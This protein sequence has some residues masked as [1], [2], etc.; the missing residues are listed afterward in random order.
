M[1][2][3]VGGTAAAALL[4]LSWGQSAGWLPP[5]GA[6]PE[7]WSIS[8][9]SIAAWGAVFLAGWTLMTG[10]MMLP[11][12]LPFLDA[13]QR[14]GGRT[15]GAVAGM[16]YTAVW[17]AVGAL[18]WIALWLAGDVLADLGPGDA[19]RIA[20]AS[21]I[22]AAIFHSTPLARECQR[23][24]AQPFAILALHWGRTSRRLHDAARA[25]LHYGAN[26]VGCCVPM[27]AIMF[28]VGVHDV[29]WLLL[30]ALA[31]LVMKHAVWGRRIALPMVAVLIVAG[32]AI[33]SGWW[34]VPLHGLRA[35]CR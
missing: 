28:V 17:V 31:M 34:S 12:S 15:A 29:A 19:E 27:V 6:R 26:C 24:C 9:W 22:A 20:G 21:L 10:A 11:S 4:L 30:M 13:V 5:H 7:A 35:L 16:A 23:A 3:V 14:V 1:A 25:G 18:Q 8:A 2:V 32:V 33:G